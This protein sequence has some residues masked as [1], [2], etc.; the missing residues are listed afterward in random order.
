MIDRDIIETEM[1]K[2]TKVVLTVPLRGKVEAKI[3]GAEIAEP[4][5]NKLR[6]SK[7]KVFALSGRRVVN[8]LLVGNA[9]V[10]ELIKT[11]TSLSEKGMM[12]IQLYAQ[13]TNISSGIDETQRLWDAKYNRV[14]SPQ[15]ETDKWFASLFDVTSKHETD[16]WTARSL[17][18]ETS[19]Q[20]GEKVPRNEILQLICEDLLQRY[21]IPENLRHAVLDGVLKSSSFPKEFDFTS[22]IRNGRIEVLYRGA[23]HQRESQ[24]LKFPVDLFLDPKELHTDIAIAEHELIHY[25]K[26]VGLI[27]ED[28]VVPVASAQTVLASH[29]SGKDIVFH[30]EKGGISLFKISEARRERLRQVAIT[31]QTPWEFYARSLVADADNL[32]S[33]ANSLAEFNQG[34]RK[35]YGEHE[36]PHTYLFGTFLGAALIEREQTVGSGYAQAYLTALAH[37]HNLWEAELMAQISISKGLT[38]EETRARVKKALESKKLDLRDTSSF[39]ELMETKAVLETNI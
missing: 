1:N 9:S 29:N 11:I 23:S 32:L 19:Q 36:E 7:S 12:N 26:T 21:G 24:E 3:V 25:F 30:T 31:A 2:D 18:K 35:Q 39:A 15:S 8:D 27:K 6:E 28:V 17:H 16:Y 20:L 13:F 38:I 22:N 34:L 10:G 33:K 14:E 5:L 4:D 37:G